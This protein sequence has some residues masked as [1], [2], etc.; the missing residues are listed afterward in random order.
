[1]QS[2][3]KYIY[4][5]LGGLFYP[6]PEWAHFFINLGSRI[7]QIDGG[8]FNITVAIAVPTRAFV[9]AFTGLGITVSRTINGKDD[10]FLGHQVI[11]ELF[12]NHRETEIIV[13]E[14]NKRV[15]RIFCGIRD[16]FP[17]GI[18][19]IGIKDPKAKGGSLTTYIFPE[20]CEFTS[21]ASGEGMLTIYRSASSGNPLTDKFI[22]HFIPEDKL[23]SFN[24]K[25]V[26]NFLLVGQ[27]NTLRKELTESVFAVIKRNGEGNNTPTSADTYYRDPFNP[28]FPEGTLQDILRVKRNI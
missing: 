27:I 1:M 23:E 12:E 16:D 11:G 5:N 9:A 14:G 18:P 10:D 13:R 3:E 15:K 26:L 25:S 22:E 17:D 20:K 4:Y 7:S 28:R 19:R 8:G 21:V 24:S 2:K 6:L